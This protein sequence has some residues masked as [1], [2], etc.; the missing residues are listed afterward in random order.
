MDE[1]VNKTDTED[2]RIRLENKEAATIKP[3]KH[4]EINKEV[5]NE[6][7]V[8][9]SSTTDNS[10]ISDPSNDNV[11]DLFDNYREDSIYDDGGEEKKIEPRHLTEEQ[12]TAH[13]TSEKLVPGYKVKKLTPDAKDAAIYT[14][15]GTEK[16]VLAGIQAIQTEI[17]EQD[18][19]AVEWIND[20]NRAVNVFTVSGDQLFEATTMP[21]SHWVNM[22]PYKE[23][24]G[25]ESHRG[26]INDR[27]G[28]NPNN[29]DDKTAIGLARALSV[30]GLGKPVY[31]PLYATGIWLKLRT[32][33]AA[34]FVALDETIVN[35]LQRYGTFTHGVI[36]TND[37]VIL[38]KHVS[39]F[40]LD[41]VEWSTAPYDSPDYLKSIIKITDMDEMI[42]AIMQTRYPDGYPFIQTC[43]V[44]PNVCR[45]TVEG[46]IDL[47]ELHWVDNSKL[48]LKQRN[49]MKSP[50][51]RLTEEELKA[52]QDEF[53][54]SSASQLV[55]SSESS[56]ENLITVDNL[57]NGIVINFDIPTIE[58]YEDYGI[59]WINQIEATVDATF[60][61]KSDVKVRAQRINERINA[62]SIK[63]YGQYVKSI[64]I[65]TEGNIFSTVTDEEELDNIFD[66]ISGEAT[67][68]EQFAK[69][70]K[71]YINLSL[72]SMV[73][74]LNYE[75]PNCG[76]KHDTPEGNFHIV[77]PIDA[78]STFFIQVRSS[79]RLNTI[80]M[81]M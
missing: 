19:N 22:I 39:D 52:Y 66:Y 64:E 50:K 44:D 25:K 15:R 76:K 67:Y 59:A 28:D 36:F 32:P 17:F 34:E 74:I 20:T 7:T 53:N 62:S 48:T 24:D 60:K 37:S 23:A 63:T 5:N 58:R 18:P 57:I 26:P 38:R 51:R 16:S 81:S 46:L 12:S 71:R 47:R 69:A 45:H 10:I 65:Y 77:L 29:K 80:K 11:D 6:D 75:C 41:H 27:K 55:I 4:T 8:V 31:T 61:E 79:L 21:N 2:S 1:T 40:I 78:L 56:E 54:N 13:R 73:G 72:V 68:I 30:L 70:I 35:E 49:M 33:T 9:D 43:T 3:A 42:R 14:V